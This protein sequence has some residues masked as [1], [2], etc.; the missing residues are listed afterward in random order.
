MIAKGSLNTGV[1]QIMNGE[2]IKEREGHLIDCLRVCYIAAKKSEF[3]YIIKK[4]N[5][6][7]SLNKSEL[8]QFF[9]FGIGFIRQSY[10]YSQGIELYEFKSLNDFSIENFA[11][12][13]TNKNYKKLISLFTLNLNHI[14]R[15]ANPKILISSFLLE[16]SNILYK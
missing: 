14:E 6:L 9:L 10:F 13:V 4:S 11:P 2:I 3:S 12:Y 16:F 1:S 15:N 7:D 8:K 5:E